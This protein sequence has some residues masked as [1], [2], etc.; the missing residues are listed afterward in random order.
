MLNLLAMF[1]LFKFFLLYVCVLNHL[2]CDSSVR[3]AN[4]NL[5]AC[6]PRVSLHS[7]LTHL[8]KHTC[9]H[10]L[11]YIKPHS[12][13][14]TWLPDCRAER[15]IH[16]ILYMSETWNLFFHIAVGVL[17][18]PVLTF[19]PEIVQPWSCLA[20][21]VPPCCCPWVSKQAAL[22]RLLCLVGHVIGYELISPG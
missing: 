1:F 10:T 2:P 13:L 6:L 19:T 18:A 14:F 4:P 8:Q 9:K 11:T 12:V 7:S 17:G 3:A 16:C 20:S 22:W 15:N 5:N 21:P